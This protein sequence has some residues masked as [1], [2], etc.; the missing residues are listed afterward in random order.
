MYFDN[1]GTESVF[2]FSKEEAKR[3]RSKYFMGAVCPICKTRQR[4][5]KTEKCV[6]CSKQ[7]ANDLLCYASGAIRFEHRAQGQIFAVPQPGL[8]NFKEHFVPFDVWQEIED[9]MNDHGCLFKV[10][11]YVAKSSHE[12]AKIGI[13]GYLVYNPCDVAGHYGIL[14]KNNRCLF[15]EEDRLK[16]SPRQAALMAGETWYMP[17]NDCPR[18]GT[19]A[20]RRV[21]DGRCRGCVPMGESRTDNRRSETSVMMAAAPNMVLSRDD[22]RKLGLKVYRTGEPCRRGHTGF[23][24]VSTGHCIDCLKGR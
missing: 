17:D 2:P 19:R 21:A 4:Y 12:A 22:A 20:E 3:I 5:V 23:R 13:H 11:P 10:G 8:R 1:D 18:C 9:L 14:N 24:W 16:P 6:F 7:W 15:C